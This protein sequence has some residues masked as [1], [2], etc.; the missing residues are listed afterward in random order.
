MKPRKK[1]IDFLVI[2][3]RNVYLKLT[4]FINETE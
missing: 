1:Y 3:N 2:F 4:E